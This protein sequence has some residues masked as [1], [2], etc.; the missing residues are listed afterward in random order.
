MLFVDLLRLTVLLIA[1]SAT[2][3]G[4]VSV[5]AAKQDDG[6]T[7]LIVAGVWWALAIV[8]GLLLGSST[9][10]GEAMS[11]AL[12]SA[13]TSTSLP[14]ESPGRIA[15]L[16]L[17]PIGAFAVI[18]G[19]LAWLL[20]Q[21][22]AVGAGFAIL[23]ALAWRNR[24]RAVSAIE[25]RDGVRFYV[26]PSSA[27][28]PIKLIRTPGLR[29]EPAPAGAPPPPPEPTMPGPGEAAPPAELR[30]PRGTARAPAPGAPQLVRTRPW[31]RAPPPPR[32]FP[33]G[34]EPPGGRSTD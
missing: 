30:P 25:E 16:R 17:W 21:V 10:A 20:P 4:A 31:R 18:V 15:F 19:A 7:T 22:A 8:L 11:R 26:E 33:Q 12:A 34:R 29:R 13:R 1:G 28:E 27:L 2:A 5:I 9:R 14:T 6:H 24:E 32:R 23:N 3:L